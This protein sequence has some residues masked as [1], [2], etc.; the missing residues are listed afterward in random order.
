VPEGAQAAVA[1]QGLVSA[2]VP[3]GARAA[4][5][6]QGLVGAPVPEGA[7]A[8]VAGQGLVG[9]PVPEGALAAVAGQ[10]WVSASMPM[11]TAAALS[12][13]GAETLGIRRAAARVG[14]D[15]KTDGS[16]GRGVARI[17]LAGPV[18]LAA[19][20]GLTGLV[21]LRAPS[22][23]ADRLVAAGLVLPIAW[24]AGAIWATMDRRLMRVAVG[25]CLTAVV[26]V[27][28]AVA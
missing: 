2:P 9:A 27:S 13:A 26:C 19:A 1:E 23:E 8:A 18:A 22:L 17:L 21:A 15:P 10:Q 14:F 24:A 20:L 25:L 11:G 6:G 7:R 5:A 16:P 4:G 3:E 28:G 12:P